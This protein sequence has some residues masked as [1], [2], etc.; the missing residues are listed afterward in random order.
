MIM[1]LTGKDITLRRESLGLNL[2]Q[3]GEML[4][5]SEACVSRWE[6]GKRRPKYEMMERLNRMKDAPKEPQPAAAT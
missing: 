3:F 4:G 2:K 6:A 1:F 5:V